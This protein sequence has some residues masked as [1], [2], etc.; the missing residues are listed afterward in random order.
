M[1]YLLACAILTAA[2]LAP[3]ADEL[4]A[5]VKAHMAPY[6]KRERHEEVT[7]KQ[8]KA[9]KDDYDRRRVCYDAV[10]LG[11][12][13]TFPEYVEDSGF[14]SSRDYMLHIG[15]LDL[16]VLAKQRDWQELIAA[17]KNGS[18][19]KVYGKLQE[20]RDEPKVKVLPR[21]YVE[22]EYLQVVEPEPQRHGH[23]PRR[24]HQPRRRRRGW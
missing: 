22:L 8:L 20:F 14:K 2:T 7:L 18:R 13:D 5:V 21:Y 24:P 16:P 10:Y 11:F 15:V 17:L 6:A 12:R 3:A 9:A 4:P 1:K 23:K 19:V